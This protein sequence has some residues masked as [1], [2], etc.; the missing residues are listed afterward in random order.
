MHQ[1]RSEQSRVTGVDPGMG[2]P[3]S[4]ARKRRAKEKGVYSKKLACA[5]TARDSEASLPPSLARMT[6][7]CRRFTTTFADR[8]E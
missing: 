6:P 7:V 2:A 8:Y 4:S 1:T 3:L 5:R